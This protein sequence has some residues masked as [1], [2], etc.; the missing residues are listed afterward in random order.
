MRVY[1]HVCS[2]PVVNA[3][4]GKPIWYP[5]FYMLIKTHKVH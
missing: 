5:I 1:F 2:S 4:Q 3:S